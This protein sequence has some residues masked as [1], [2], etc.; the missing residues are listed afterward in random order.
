MPYSRQFGD[1]YYSKS[2]GRAE[3]AHVFIQ[4]NGLDKRFKTASQITIAEL[5]FG[6]GLNFL[7]TMR[8]FL[9]ITPQNAKL[10]FHSFELFPLERQAAEKALKQWPELRSMSEQMLEQW[11][12]AFTE[13]HVFHFGDNITLYIYKG[14]AQKRVKD[15][16]FTADAWYLDG[17]APARNEKMWSLE[18]MKDLAKRTRNGGTLA[19]YTAAGW[20]RRNLQE[21]GFEIEKRPGFGSKRD[22]ISGVKPA[23]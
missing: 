9:K 19:S 17:F 1:Y 3:C 6:T 23:D 21:A 12:S 14:D 5:G 4:G 8:Q 13:D 18:L 11:P 20:V 15:T 16:D 10:A 22:M 2:D 7:E